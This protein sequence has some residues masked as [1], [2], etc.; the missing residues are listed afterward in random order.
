MLLTLFG[1]SVLVFVMLRV[2]PGNILVRQVGTVIHPGTGVGMGRDYTIYAV[3]TGEVQYKKRRGDRTFVSVIPAE[4][5]PQAQ[6]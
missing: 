4:A 6:A 5:K 3:V 1:I 2:V